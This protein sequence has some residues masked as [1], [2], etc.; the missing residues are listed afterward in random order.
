MLGANG[1]FLAKRFVE[2]GLVLAASG[3]LFAIV[4]FGTLLLAK[5]S[6]FIKS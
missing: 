1:G 4:Y 5:K 3:I 2:V 6:Q